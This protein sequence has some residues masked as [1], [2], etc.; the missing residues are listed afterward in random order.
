MIRLGYYENLRLRKKTKPFN[1]DL[2]AKMEP[3]WIQIPL[4]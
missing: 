4:W 2:K 1:I 3:T